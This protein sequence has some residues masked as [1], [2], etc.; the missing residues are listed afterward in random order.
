MPSQKKKEKKERKK[1]GK[2]EFSTAVKISESQTAA[3]RSP[4]RGSAGPPARTLLG[5][6]D[7]TFA[8]VCHFGIFYFLLVQLILSPK[9]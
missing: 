3:P 5:L 1:K 6:L 7:H 2:K 8:E 9:E 4:C